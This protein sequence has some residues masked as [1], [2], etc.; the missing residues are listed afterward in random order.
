MRGT[1]TIIDKGNVR[2]HSYTAPA[3]DRHQQLLPVRHPA[4]LTA[5]TSRPAPAP[6]ATRRVFDR[7]V[8]LAK[9]I[10]GFLTEG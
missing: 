9:I 10:A 3:R 7:Q 6:I 1:I 5:S 2:V 8:E 4:R